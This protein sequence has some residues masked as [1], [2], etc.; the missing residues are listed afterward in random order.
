MDYLE[1][2]NPEQLEAVKKVEGYNLV[3]AG[4][5]TGK[6]HT[7][8]TKVAYMID[9][10]IPAK[11][12]LMLTFT[13]KAAREMVDRI[14]K[15]IGDGG[16]AV[17]ASTFHSFFVK[18]LR[19]YGTFLQSSSF[20][21]MSENDRKVLVKQCRLLWRS[22]HKDEIDPSELQIYNFPKDT[23]LLEFYSDSI[24]SLK[25]YHALLRKKAEKY[26]E[27][28]IAHYIEYVIDILKMYDEH[29]RKYNLMDFDD[30]LKNAYIMLKKSDKVR[31]LLNQKYRYVI[32]DEYQDTNTIQEAILK[33]LTEEN[34]NLTVVGDDN[35][36]IYAFRGAEIENI[37]TFADRYPDVTTIKLVR[38]YRSTQEILDFS[39]AFMHHAKEGIKKDLIGSKHG[40]MVRMRAYED[41]SVMS[42]AIVNEIIEAHENGKQ[43]S[44]IAVIARSGKHLN[45]IESILTSKQ[46]PYEKFGGV[47]YFDSVAVQ[48]VLAFVRVAVNKLDAVAW[49]RVLQLYTN[50]ATVTSTRLY[51]NMIEHR[52]YYE[53]LMSLKYAKRVYCK[54][55]KGLYDAIKYIQANGN[56]VYKVMEF[57]TQNYYQKVLIETINNSRMEDDQKRDQIKEAKKTK[58]FLEPLLKLSSDY[59]DL[60]KFT[61]EMMLARDDKNS[62]EDDK[63]NLT[64]IHSAK[65]LEYDTVYVINTVQKMF[66]ITEV[67]DIEDPEELRCMYVACTRAKNTLKLY[68]PATII[69]YEFQKMDI[70]DSELSHFIAYEDVMKTTAY[71]NTVMQ[72][73]QRAMQRQKTDD[74]FADDLTDMERKEIEE[75][76]KGDHLSITPP[77]KGTE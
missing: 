8:I 62:A 56:D 16:I 51:E 53:E 68:M 70:V 24:N 40:D 36:S 35:Q 33:M 74:M 46:I 17:T 44:D 23:D 41:D 65:G 21:I 57:L 12:I 5:G 43:Y 58:K 69:S 38:N 52:S 7:M 63:V 72:L 14:V 34:G 60:T 22:E 42:N 27:C 30:I 18:I 32:C 3:I 10:G 31:H 1:T 28:N 9:Q 13:N 50:I 76:G 39:N 59:S 55:L 67:Y 61:E 77:L 47:K 75:A 37:L 11:E 45:G 20:T 71:D 25:S 2:L 29:K 6:T 48:D 26:C 66:P 73:Y 19:R 54:Q 15:Y 4:A 64:T 49:H